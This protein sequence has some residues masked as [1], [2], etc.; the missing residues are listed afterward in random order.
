MYLYT[1]DHKDNVFK[2]HTENVV[3]II[4]IDNALPPGETVTE[5]HAVET[6]NCAFQVEVDGATT[7]VD[8]HVES[9]LAADMGWVDVVSPATEVATGFADL[10]SINISNLSYLR[11][12][13]VNN[14]DTNA[15]H[16]RAVVSTD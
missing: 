11:V 1:F 6:A 15:G 14:D 2:K 7:N 16:V 3:D 4:E 10:Q 9:R 12:R 13:V 5:T 8:I